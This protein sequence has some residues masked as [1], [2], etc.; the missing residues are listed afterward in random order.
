MSCYNRTDLIRR[1]GEI[2]LYMQSGRV[3]NIALLEDINKQ[4][5]EI[6]KNKTFP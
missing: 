6:L 3:C 1:S 4:F 2:V 5:R